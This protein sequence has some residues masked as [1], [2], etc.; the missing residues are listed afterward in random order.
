M[1]KL[2]I[3]REIGTCFNE[4]NEDENCRVIVLSGAGRLFTAGKQYM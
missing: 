3:F 2:H 1:L 4:L